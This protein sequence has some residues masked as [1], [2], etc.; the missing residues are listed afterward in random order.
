[1]TVPFEPLFYVKSLLLFVCLLICRAAAVFYAL[2]NDYLTFKEK[3]FATLNIPK[4]VAM[5]VVAFSF[6]VMV[7]SG[8]AL[9]AGLAPM[10]DYMLAIL[11]YTLVL[12]TIVTRMSKQLIHI[13]ISEEANQSS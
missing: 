1:V 8:E 13:D 2:E 11:V 4:G 6:T 3:L 5:A 12:S 7:N 9:Y 10:L